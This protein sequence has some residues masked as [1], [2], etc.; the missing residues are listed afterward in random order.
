MLQPLLAFSLFINFI[1][2]KF[3]RLTSDFF[4]GLM[5][6]QDAAALVR[7]WLKQALA[8]E[9]IQPRTRSRAGPVQAAE[10]QSLVEELSQVPGGQELD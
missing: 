6:L 7:K 3:N 4:W 9:H 2:L 10:L 8:A 5:P 1:L